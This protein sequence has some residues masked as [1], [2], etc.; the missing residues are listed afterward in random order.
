MTAWV[1]VGVVV[2]GESI[3]VD[4]VNPWEHKWQVSGQ[5]PVDLPHPS[6]LNQLHTMNVVK[7]ET[8]DREVIFAT[9]ELSANVWVF[10]V[11]A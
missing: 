10:Y 4:G 3:L 5:P 1:P 7:V 9:C 8:G 6:Y 11:Q 2:E